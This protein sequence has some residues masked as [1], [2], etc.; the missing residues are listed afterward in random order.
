MTKTQRTIKGIIVSKRLVTVK[1]G[2]G[3]G[4]AS[5]S[6]IG[7]IAGGNLGSNASDS[8][9]GAIAGAVIGG[10]VGA[11]AQSEAFATEATE[12]IVDSKVAGLLTV[13]TNDSDLLV[14]DNVYIILGNEPKLVK[15]PSL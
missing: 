4:T 15:N 13:V 14:G 8:A 11:I 7:G 12:Y 6:A 3:V 1:G 5:G 9:V 2:R 10:T